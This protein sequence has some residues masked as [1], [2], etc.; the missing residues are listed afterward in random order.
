M[1]NYFVFF[2]VLCVV[3]MSCQKP[4]AVDYRDIRN[5]TVKSLGFDNSVISMDLVYYNPNNFAIDIRRVECDV[6]INDNFVGKYSLD[7]LS[8]VGKK[9]EFVLPSKMQV[10]MKTV[11]KNTFTVLFNKEI[12]LHLKGTTKVGKGGVFFNFPFNY[13]GKHNFSVFQ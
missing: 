10:D 5:I 6:F 11:F 13:S 2:I 9:T 12:T 7:T 4:Q 1:K 8:H 3:L